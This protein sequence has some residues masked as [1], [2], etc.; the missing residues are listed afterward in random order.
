MTAFSRLNN[1]LQR[2]QHSLSPNI[3]KIKNKINICYE[4]HNLKTYYKVL[5]NGEI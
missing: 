1:V 3:R 4:L 2:P 5:K